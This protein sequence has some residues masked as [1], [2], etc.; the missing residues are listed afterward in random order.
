MQLKSTLKTVRLFTALFSFILLQSQTANAQCTPVGGASGTVQNSTGTTPISFTVAVSSTASITSLGA[1]AGQCGF[2]FPG[3]VTPWS[4]NTNTISTVTYTFSHPITSID[5]FIGYTGVNTYIRP[6]SFTFT[7]DTDVP[8]LSV[9]SGTC[10]DWTI[11]GNQT[12]SPN[13]LHAMNSI[14]TVTT[15]NGFTTLTIATNSGHNQNGGSSYALCDGSL[16][17]ECPATS[18]QVSVTSCDSYTFNSQTYDSTGIYTQVL[19]NSAGCDSVITL[20]LVINDAT[21]SS[22]TE[23]ACNSCG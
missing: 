18:S 20:D 21:T 5:I 23:T 22:L 19:T 15:V 16:V 10:V 9:N 8:T 4:G 14:H 6:E 17:L 2:T 12:T 11:N 7:T 13:I 1:Y 3:I